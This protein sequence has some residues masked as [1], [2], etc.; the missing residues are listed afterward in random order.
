MTFK[1]ILTTAQF[2]YIPLCLRTFERVVLGYQIIKNA[3]TF[4]EFSS[5]SFRHLRL[6]SRLYTELEREQYIESN[7]KKLLKFSL[8]VPLLAT[9]QR[10]ES[11]YHTFSSSEIIDHYVSFSHTASE[12]RVTEMDN[13]YKVFV[14]NRDT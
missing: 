14:M 3:E 10:K 4:L 8:P 9:L 2:F 6:C 1:Q 13:Q 12:G 5:K 7:L 11:L